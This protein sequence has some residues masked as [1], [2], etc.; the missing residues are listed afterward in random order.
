MS[1]AVTAYLYCLSFPTLLQCIVRNPIAHLWARTVAAGG[2]TS[3]YCCLYSKSISPLKLN[4]FYRCNAVVKR[5]KKL[6]GLQP[7]TLTSSCAGSPFGLQA[8][9]IGRRSRPCACLLE[10]F[11][12]H[13]TR[14][15][16]HC[17]SFVESLRFG[18][19]IWRSSQTRFTPP[20]RA[21]ARA[22]VCATAC[23][24]IPPALFCFIV[25]LIRCATAHSYWGPHHTLASVCSRVSVARLLACCLSFTICCQLQLCC[26]NSNSN[27]TFLLGVFYA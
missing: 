19:T 8:T 16:Q 2:A 25:K 3:V 9:K 26:C 24:G 27:V 21:R 7:S 15:P 13:A 22:R 5:F 11:G 17:K 10:R 12:L 18:Q 20:V 1:A 6:S 23:D 4:I 14:T